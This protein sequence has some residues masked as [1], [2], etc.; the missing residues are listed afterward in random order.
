MIT[1]VFSSCICERIIN[2]PI[3]YILLQVICNQTLGNFVRESM[4]VHVMTFDE[5]DDIHL[6][7]LTNT[8]ISVRWMLPSDDSV[9][10]FSIHY[11]RVRLYR[12]G[13]E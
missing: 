8:T 12:G 5:P 7:D 3:L 4:P 9:S 13:V 6:V 2:N 10:M 11:A 1:L